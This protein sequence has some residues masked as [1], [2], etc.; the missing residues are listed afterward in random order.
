MLSLGGAPFESNMGHVA[1]VGVRHLGRDR[2]NVFWGF[3]WLD[4]EPFLDVATLGVGV[5]ARVAED[6]TG[7]ALTQRLSTRRTRVAAV[8]HGSSSTACASSSGISSGRRDFVDAVQAVGDGLD[9]VL[10]LLA[11]L[12]IGLTPHLRLRPTETRAR[13]RA[14][15]VCQ[16]PCAVCVCCSQLSQSAEA[17]CARHHLFAQKLWRCV[18]Y[19]RTPQFHIVPHHFLVQKRVAPISR[20]LCENNEP[21]ESTPHLDSSHLN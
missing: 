7:V 4:G 2:A 10:H 16:P 8:A 21:N 19:V 12:P 14:R 18:L 5:A 3:V 15:H 17:V 6:T 20:S 13:Q 11:L 9:E 1:K